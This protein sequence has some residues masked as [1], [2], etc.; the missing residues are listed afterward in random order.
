M[1]LGLVLSSAV[2]GVLAA[3]TRAYRLHQQLVRVQEEGRFGL[4]SLAADLADRCGAIR[5]YECGSVRCSP[6]LPTDRSLPERARAANVLIVDTPHDE[7]GCVSVAWYIANGPVAGERELRRCVSGSNCQSVAQGLNRLDFTYAVRDAQQRVRHLDAAEVDGESLWDA[8][9]GVD[10]G[11]WI[12][13]RDSEEE[14]S[15]IRHEFRTFVAL[16]RGGA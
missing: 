13:Q 8:V 4:G 7:K 1:A 2:L 5:G 14:A 3:S 11:L 15:A 9:V 12:E 10:I 16:P 6:A